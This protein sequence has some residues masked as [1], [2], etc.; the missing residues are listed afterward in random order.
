MAFKRPSLAEIEARVRNDLFP[1][2]GGAPMRVS[3]KGLLGKAIAGASHLL[4]GHIAAMDGAVMPDTSI[5]ENL[6]R[7]AKI[8][9]VSRKLGGKASG[10][11]AFKGLTGS[12]IPAGLTL[13]HALSGLD[14]TTDVAALIEEGVALVQATATDRGAEA[15]L[16]AG[17]P[18]V[19]TQTIPGIEEATVGNPGFTG[20]S[21]VESLEN[22]QQRY[23]FKLAN[24]S[25][26]G[27]DADYV[28]LAL[29]VQHVTRAWVV[30][31]VAGIG[32]VGVSVLFDD[33]DRPG[34]PLPDRESKEFKA[35]V[36]H[37]KT[38]CP[39]TA[40]A[41][42][43]VFPPKPMWRQVEARLVVGE[44]QDERLVKK[45]IEADLR[46]IFR[47][48]AQLAGAKVIGTPERRYSGTIYL[49][50]ILNVFAKSGA[51]DYQVIWPTTNITPKNL[52]I[53]LLT[54]VNWVD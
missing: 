38:H 41:G 50:Q 18:L 28:N 21:E 30:P 13:R 19:V 26:G 44:D 1:P 17:E 2:E 5:P 25:T 32:T 45:Q 3:L 9:S 34:R 27:D 54:G 7:W 16:S 40:R 33:L 11:V 48:Q 49:S 14:F 46:T 6:L 51:E 42:L 47:E 23:L 35:V 12:K 43:A 31:S 22:L 4:H 29:A 37:I 53:L 39:A 20:G 24:P 36:D 10:K 8:L 15:N 52:H